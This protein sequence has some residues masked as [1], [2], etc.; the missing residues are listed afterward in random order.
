SLISSLYLCL[1]SKQKDP[2]TIAEPALVSA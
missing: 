2:D 1:C